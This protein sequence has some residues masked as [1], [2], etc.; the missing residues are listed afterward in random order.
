[1]LRIYIIMTLIFVPFLLAQSAN[2]LVDD[3]PM[4]GHHDRTTYQALWDTL[5]AA[6]AD[7]DFTSEMGR[8]PVLDDFELILLMHHY[9]CDSAGFSYSQRGQMIEYTCGGGN[10]I[11]MPIVRDD[12]APTN[13]LL[14]DPRWRT[15]LYFGGAG[16]SVNSTNIA[17]FPPYTD[18]IEYLLFEITAV[19]EAIPPAWP[20][21]WDETGR[22]VIAAIS[23]PESDSLPC[24]C[25]E[26][27]RILALADNHTFEAPVVGYI[28]PMDHLF[29]VN[30]MMAMCGITIELPPCDI[31]PEIPYAEI[32]T[33]L[34]PGDLYIIE[35]AN[36]HS[37]LTI[38]IGSISISPIG[39]APDSSW[40]EFIVPELSQGFYDVLI[41]DSIYTVH[42]G[43][44][45]IYCEWIDISSFS[46]G[47]Y[48]IGDSVFFY[49]E[50][51]PV[52]NGFIEI[53]SPDFLDTVSAGEYEIT[54]DTDG[55][56]IM[57]EVD[58]IFYHYQ[59]V[60]IIDSVF[61]N[62]GG[63][64]V[65]IP[66]PCAG[67]GDLYRIV[68]GKPTP[69][70]TRDPI[71]EI[72][73]PDSCFSI[74]GTGITI[75]YSTSADSF[76]AHPDLWPERERRDAVSFYIS[77]DSVFTP[78]ARNIP[79]TGLFEW[80]PSGSGD[81]NIATRA[82]DYF[83]NMGTDT[84]EFCVEI[85]DE[86]SFTGHIR[87]WEGCE[88][89][90]I[91][92]TIRNRSLIDTL[93][94]ALE[95]D[96]RRFRFPENMHWNDDTTLVFIPPAE[97]LEDSS[98]HNIHMS[99]MVSTTS[100]IRIVPDDEGLMSI[101]R[102]DRTPPDIELIFPDEDSIMTELPDS[103]AFR[104]EDWLGVHETS[105]WI[106]INEDS[107]FYPDTLLYFDDSILSADLSGFSSDDSIFEICVGASDID[108]PEECIA[109]S[110]ECYDFSTNPAG[111]I[112]YLS[113]DDSLITSCEMQSIIFIAN[114]PDII[115]ETTLELYISS[116]GTITAID[117][118]TRISGD[119]IIFSPES[120]WP[121]CEPIFVELLMLRDD[122][123]RP[124]QG[125]PA[126]GEFQI[127]K[128][129]PEFPSYW[130]IGLV[131][132]I[133]P[134]ITIEVS[135]ECTG[136]DLD[137]LALIVDGSMVYG[138]GDDGFRWHEGR[139]EFSY[140]D[141]SIE[142]AANDTDQICIEAKDLAK[143]CGA[144]S[145][146]ACFEIFRSEIIC[147]L[148][149][150]IRPLENP[151]CL[152]DT[153]WIEIDTRGGFGNIEMEFIPS[154]V[155]FDES[156]GNYFT[157]LEETTDL[158]AIARD[159]SGCT[160][161]DTAIIVILPLPAVDIDD[162]IVCRDE[163][164]MIDADGYFDSLY[165]SNGDIGASME[166]TA[167]FEQR[168]YFVDAFLQGC[169]IRDS[170]VIY[171][172]KCDSADSFECN[173]QVEVICPGN[174]ICIGDSAS[175]S[176]EAFDGNGQIYFEWSPESL[177]VDSEAQENYIF[178]ND[179]VWVFLEAWDDSSCYDYDSCF[180]AVI[181][182]SQPKDVD[183]Y[184]H[185]K[186]FT[187]NDDGINENVILE[188]PEMQSRNAIAYIYTLDNKLLRK[189]TSIDTNHE[190]AFLWDGR[191]SSGTLMPNGPYLY[192]IEQDGEIICHGTVYIM[193]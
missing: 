169:T 119:S 115:D 20:F 66:C 117:S 105:I 175:I 144:N 90:S 2:V 24:D 98:W 127:D 147:D 128:I 118:M 47:C 50:N 51:L 130:P 61:G 134:E 160:A 185:P 73:P 46:S 76:M 99:S 79:N 142:I 103:L 88:P 189:L 173:L 15:G 75:E 27:G 71:I 183:C 122:F 112:D 182:C 168:Q 58:T 150:N 140:F 192:V 131:D 186:P 9:G 124:L 148:N 41:I 101:F 86:P 166:D 12:L 57:P 102:I 141:A 53:I 17:E 84:A 21:A 6:G 36:L 123:G 179:S 23:Y 121:S 5:E 172:E 156:S 30:A 120:E 29:M 155:E 63:L 59:N 7:I 43:S 33:C 72:L 126:S 95:I 165:W 1:M 181:D 96:D 3:A 56:L 100:G 151:V 188:Y 138:I 8:F 83:G 94:L 163:Y 106:S 28:E 154:T 187:P 139:I 180:I 22:Q 114:R 54:S 69:A 89:E 152:G 19:I 4:C 82:I 190:G 149:M 137:S 39:T 191:N 177:I 193:R 178:P 68:D 93:T 49:G 26:G 133:Y 81:F 158:I 78:L 161:I 145:N 167:D 13:S 108:F 77:N 170:F 80:M 16:G 92:F 111:R 171:T 135:D 64:Y 48:N 60:E 11:I 70:D 87:P 107:I 146:R 74:Y 159:D 157:I 25:D 91:L 31:P 113:P 176:A 85:P 110:I 34:Y 40:M 42:A 109:S 55:W 45:Q 52:E 37:G 35:G 65:Q 104:I 14:N 184:A 125:L 32:D 44:L 153:S 162:S 164:F 10:V 38:R 129:P 97:L 132:T 62:R 116:I 18:G 174:A 67:S 136:I 143:E